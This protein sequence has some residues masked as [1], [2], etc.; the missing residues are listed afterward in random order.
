[1]SAVVV[2]VRPARPGDEA[3]IWGLIQ[4][5]AASEG[6]EHELD[7]NPE[8]LAR[9]VFAPAPIAFSLVAEEG[10]ALVGYAMGY[11]TFDSYTPGASVLFLSDLFVCSARRGAGIGRALLAAM[12]RLAVARGALRLE[13]DVIRHNTAALAF[14]RRAGAEDD[15]VWCR[16][17]LAGPALAALAEEAAR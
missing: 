17:R 15:P 11:P 5:L 8:A 6:L 12:A 7:G 13:W 2:A 10:G 4:G 9:A 1:V 16:Q 3:Q 14:Y